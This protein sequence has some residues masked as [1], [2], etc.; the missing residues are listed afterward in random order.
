MENVAL[1][2]GELRYS[3]NAYGTI[4]SRTGPNPRSATFDE[5]HR[6][7]A[8]PDETS[9]FFQRL[10]SSVRRARSR[11]GQNLPPQLS[12]LQAMLDAEHRPQ[13]D[14]MRY[15]SSVH[16][17]QPE[18]DQSPPLDG[19]QNLSPAALTST[20]SASEFFDRQD[21]FPAYILDYG[22]HLP[23]GEPQF[24]E[25]Y[26]AWQADPKNAQPDSV[27][28]WISVC[29]PTMSMLSQLRGSLQ[30]HPL[31]VDDIL[32]RTQRAKVEIYNH[33]QDVGM[34]EST[35]IFVVAHSPCLG[36]A[37]SGFELR[38]SQVSVFTNTGKGLLVTVE[39]RTAD[40]PASSWLIQARRHIHWNVGDIRS[41][42]VSFL[43]YMIVDSIVDQ[44][45]PILE[46]QGDVLDKL[47]ECV[48]QPG[49]SEP[50]LTQT[51]TI[52]LI[53]RAK[54]DL[55]GLRRRLFPL[56]E[57]VRF[58]SI[59]SPALGEV[60]TK[61][62]YRDIL[63]HVHTLLDM[64]ESY[65]DVAHSLIELHHSGQN[66]RAQEIMQNLAVVSVICLPL[67]FL[68]GVYGMNF[69]YMPEVN[70]RL[71]YP[72]FLVFCVVVVVGQVVYFRRRGWITEN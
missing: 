13:T 36:D 25:D 33:V 45:F 54:R 43:L 40:A 5:A 52:K 70:M 59:L 68:T 65:R 30:F 2:L 26:M 21:S 62:Y 64:L 10:G 23:R 71:A 38:M 48:L 50:Y 69:S 55:L 12:V 49:E 61:V 9:G 6:V 1:H 41:K 24:T 31:V 3:R 42:K 63:D 67:T 37:T 39:E 57:S 17:D 56:K 28:R 66:L 16:L 58:L 11:S 32:N 44:F 72:V 18:S 60:D 19:S 35:D 27:V 46:H 4:A 15:S 20:D 22:P 8:Q 53:A 34:K 47:E 7:R 14:L 51:N 29:S